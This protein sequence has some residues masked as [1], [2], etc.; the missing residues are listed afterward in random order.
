MSAIG[1]LDEFV[2]KLD[3]LGSYLDSVSYPD[4]GGFHT[5]IA[6]ERLVLLGMRVAYPLAERINTLVE[7]HAGIN[8]EYLP[9][10]QPGYGLFLESK[11]RHGKISDIPLSSVINAVMSNTEGL[12]PWLKGE[13]YVPVKQAVSIAKEVAREFWVSKGDLLVSLARVLLENA[14]PDIL[15]SVVE[16]GEPYYDDDQTLH[17][18]L[19]PIIRSL[20]KDPLSKAEEVCCLVE[21]YLSVILKDLGVDSVNVIHD[22]DD[23]HS[24][25]SSE[26]NRGGR[27]L[28]S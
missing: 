16:F 6:L 11:L 15:S 7:R 1:H 9:S 17:L 12:K 26:P 19:T 22:L 23:D 2:D 28:M 5:L 14:P 8:P 4:C 18:T 25:G 24:F 3:D 27:S 13:I 20:D 10:Y 21:S